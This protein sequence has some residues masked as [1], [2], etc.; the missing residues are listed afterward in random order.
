MSSS[1]ADLQL[2]IDVEDFLSHYWQRKP[3]LIRAADTDFV[4]PLSADELGGLALEEEIESRLVRQQGEDWLVEHGPFQVEDFQRSG[5]WTLLV[6]A[7]DE[8]IPEV[9]ELRQ[10]VNFLPNW[11]G[12]DVMVS[13]ATDG[14]SVGPH[15]D[16]YD[17]FLLQGEG[18]RLWRLGQ[19]CDEHTPLLEGQSLRILQDFQCQEEYL[20]NP[21]DILYVPPGLAHWGIAQGECTTFS[22]GFRAPAYQDLLA[23][24]VDQALENLPAERFFG[25]PGREAANLPGELSEGDIQRALEQVCELIMRPERADWL[26]ELVTET[27]YMQEPEPFEQSDVEAVVNGECP[28]YRELSARIAWRE[29]NGELSVYANGATLVTELQYREAIIELCQ[30][31]QLDCSAMQS[32]QSDSASL[33]ELIHFLL[34]TGSCYV[35][36]E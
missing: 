25:D 21:G 15:F 34:E 8:L 32:A 18:Q 24:R 20:L 33:A 6:Q 29:D 17:V 13:Y 30:N 35:D 14:G 9:A 23:R 19:Q 11:R 3:L 22:I 7:V 1:G 31:A 2:N 16:H 5:P 36:D 27:R 26:G 28:L 10:L 4:P 12:D